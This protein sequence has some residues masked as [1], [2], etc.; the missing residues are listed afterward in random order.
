MTFAIS[1]IGA[2]TAGANAYIPLSEL[3]SIS[4]DTGASYIFRER[5]QRFVPI[6]FS[7]RVA[8]SPAPSR[9]RSSASPERKAAD[10]LSD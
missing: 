5:G 7:V 3:A 9:K 2:P 6:K 10:R 4:L 8:I 1:K